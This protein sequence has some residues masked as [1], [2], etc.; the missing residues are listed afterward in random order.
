[1][2][3]NPSNFRASRNDPRLRRV[4]GQDPVP[5]E[6]QTQE[7]QAIQRER[8]TPASRQQAQEEAR[9][10]I[11][12]GFNK[13]EPP[14]GTLTEEDIASSYTLQKL[15]AEPGDKFIDGQLERTVSQKP[16]G[17]MITA[18][19][20]SISPTLQNAGAEPGDM[21]E[22]GKIIKSGKNAPFRNFLYGLKEG[23]D[24]VESFA[25]YM[26]SYMPLP[27]I[28]INFE[29]G[30]QFFD[31]FDEGFK[32][33]TPEQRRQL[34]REYKD[35][36]LE[37]MREDFEPDRDTFSFGAGNLAGE[38]GILSVVP[39][40]AGTRLGTLAIEGALF[41]GVDFAV[42]SLA[43][44]GELPPA[45]ELAERGALGF[46]GGAGASLV[47]SAGK[48]VAA[49]VAEGRA[50]RQALKTQQDVEERIIEKVAVGES[51]STAVREVQEEL[52]FSDE[53]LSALA[54]LTNKKLN[55]P[56]T[57]S[58]ARQAAMFD[59]TNDS[60][61]SRQKSGAVDR[62]LGAIHTRIKNISPSVAGRLRNFEADAHRKTADNLLEVQPFVRTLSRLPSNI[63][64]QVDL[65]LFNGNFNAARGLI[66]SVAP[67]ELDNFET[68]LKTINRIGDELVESGYEMGRVAN[69]FPRLIKDLDG[70]RKSLGV[71]KRSLIDDALRQAAR[72][73]KVEV[74]DLSLDERTQI[75]DRVLRGYTPKT[76]D[77]KLSFTKP[78]TIE[79][80]AP[81]QLKFYEDANTALQA[82]IR[83]SV[84]DIEKRKFFG[85]AA[86][87][88]DDGLL[89]TQT[90]IG[91]LVDQERA[92]GTITPEG[93]LS[94]QDMLSARFIG[95]EKSPASLIQGVRDIGYASTI[96]NPYTALINLDELSRSAAIYGFRN[97]LTGLFGKK[98]TDVVELGLRN[99][100]EEFESPEKTARFLRSMFSAS[101]FTKLDRLGKDA[102]VN[103]ALRRFMSKAQTVK[104]RAELRRQYGAQF[105]DE[106]EALIQNLQDR[107]VTDNVKQ[108]AFSALADL[109]PIARSEMPEWYLRNPDGRILYQL[110]SFTLKQYDL[111]RNQ[112][113]R[114]FR[115]GS[116]AQAAKKAAVL[117]AYMTASGT[118]LDSIRDLML[119]REVKPEDIP[120]RAMWVLLAPYGMNKYL[121]ERYFQRG[122]I[123]EGITNIIAP[124]TPL[125]DELTSLIANTG[126]YTSGEKEIEDDLFKA[127]NDVPVVGKLIYNWL[128]GGAERW[129]ERE[130]ELREE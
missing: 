116:K 102:T 11:E 90:S 72:S 95:G 58:K 115:T 101:G 94:L 93:E 74:N 122:D 42:E 84:D 120:G 80:I 47:L 75:I 54:N 117:M 82:Y 30:F 125:I 16:R 127:I 130:E 3:L 77:N 27:N 78:R 9:Q 96:A 62:L 64:S 17:E 13:P 111:V 87:N 24:L 113:V 73:R 26:N 129:N 39:L 99:A 2:A 55:I 19:D 28:N 45:P 25:N 103:A 34:L 7:E 41:S 109:Q 88:S 86:I 97:T 126:Q 46:S 15:G 59:V 6:G 40:T 76:V 60:V 21:L 49:N 112:I 50:R 37:K 22:D 89:D 70:L 68:A 108:L 56:S 83:R 18:Y 65:Q 52:G 123:T 119:G 69:Y 12:T 124:A 53:Y 121:S 106:T 63:R 105:G 31:D 92:R 10:Q 23:D 14:P 71:E 29:N 128:G 38:A 51:P 35:A 44:S 32:N 61:V 107:T 110:K 100:A 57:Q 8:D 67:D 43:E 81:E 33:A 48:R 5:E 91:R 118:A 114:E 85:R 4:P 20:I 36:E 79:K 1:M 104:G 66:K 98:Y